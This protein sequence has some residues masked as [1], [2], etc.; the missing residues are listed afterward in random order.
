MLK[1]FTLLNLLLPCI[2]AAKTFQIDSEKFF[3]SQLSPPLSK[4]ILAKH[5]IIVNNAEA[6]LKA[7]KQ[8]NKNGNTLIYLSKGKYKLNQTL[9]IKAD[10]IYIISQSKNPFDTVISGQGMKSTNGTNNLIRVSGSN[11]YLEGVVL[12]EAANHLIQIAGE[13]KASNPIIRNCVLQ[14]GYEQLLKVSYNINKPENFSSNG[15]IENNLFR[16]TAGI[17]P[18]YYIGGIDAHG[19]QHWVIKHNVFDGIASPNKHIAEH[20]IHLWNNSAHNKV[21]DN[22]IINSDRGIG[23]GMRNGINHKLKYGN[24]GGEIRRNIIYHANNNHPF[25]D[26]GITLEDSPETNIINNIIL[27]EHKYR[28][29]IEYRFRTTFNVYIARNLSNKAISK[30]DGANAILLENKINHQQT[31]LALK[32]RLKEYLTN[33]L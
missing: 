27:L 8:A 24:L 9:N 30:R 5:S 13:S 29:A 31:K 25:A 16:Y 7:V 32:T 10:N 22:L 12:E 4:I 11:F 14:N 20:A 1:L 2:L 6:L 17:G 3:L 19:I 28:S 26:A 33:Q 15:L 23:F 18:N 21:V